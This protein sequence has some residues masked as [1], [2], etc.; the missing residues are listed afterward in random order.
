LNAPLC[1]Y[2]A[3]MKIHP[4]VVPVDEA[5]PFKEALFDRKALGLSLTQLLR[6][7]ED[8]LVIFVHAPWGEGKTTFSRMWLA[9]LKSEKLQ[10]IYFDAYASDYV[11]DPFVC[12]SGE[13]LEFADKNLKDIAGLEEPKREFK[14]KALEVGKQLAG[15]F[16]KVGIRAAT[17][18]AV[19]AADIAELKDIGTE[20]AEGAGDIGAGLIEK[21]IEN[22]A[23]EKDSLKAFRS[24][25][26]TLAKKV[27][28]AQGFPLTIVVDELDR[29]R[30]DFALSLLE[31]IK[32][33]FDVEGVAFVLLVNR[34]QIESYVNALYGE[35]VDARAYLLKFGNLFVDLP[36][37][38]AVFEHRKG[39]KE[40]SRSLFKHYEFAEAIEE[41][42]FLARSVEVLVEHF[43]LTLRE[44]EKVFLILNLY[45]SSLPKNELTNGFLVAMLA[46]FKVK[47]P[48]LY[49]QL[50]RGTIE[51]ADF[52]AQTKLDKL[53]ERDGDGV[54]LPWILN[55]LDFCLLSDEKM[56][57]LEK[58][59]S[60]AGGQRTGP[61]AMYN[62][63]ARYSVKRTKVIP[64]FASRLDQF[65]LAP[66]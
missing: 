35:K 41:S 7:V 65:T 50:R 5:D 14:K 62:W 55:M 39:R 48:D 22:Y 19:N 49:L 51:A 18:G 66:K 21:K 32:H 29:C 16:T 34:D 6:N 37:Q 8:S 24:S 9:H 25:L 13:I 60:E 42:D 47:R 45:Y 44:I 46:T 20:V 30:P 54:N 17:M 58:A 10:A 12:F 40:F 1:Q 56:R 43:D 38:Q 64:F 2:T 23:A 53:R 61:T 4:P 15:L 52:L 59:S 27:R 31:R 11:E 26:A 28:D 36:S 57:E 3:L 63:L 33:L